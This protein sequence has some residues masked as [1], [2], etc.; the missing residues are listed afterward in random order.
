[1]TSG[2]CE[3]VEPSDR[4]ADGKMP[5]SLLIALIDVP[6]F[7]TTVDNSSPVSLRR[8]RMIF[9][10]T[11]SLKSRELRKYF[12]LRRFIWFLMVDWWGHGQAGVYAAL[13]MTTV[14]LS[15]RCRLR[16]DNRPEGQS[17]PRLRLISHSARLSKSEPRQRTSATASLLQL[18]FRQCISTH[19]TALLQNCRGRALLPGHNHDVRTERS[20]FG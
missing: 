11:R 6:A 1:L 4:S 5:A 14:S 3:R 17:V 13:A 19:G 12:A 20:S 7:R 9:T 16:E 2:D 15:R 8:F 18:K 10:W